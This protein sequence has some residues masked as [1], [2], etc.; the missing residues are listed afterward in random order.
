MTDQ[1]AAPKAA[2]ARRNPPKP[3]RELRNGAAQLEAGA[4]VARLWV[5]LCQGEPHFA[6]LIVPSELRE[7][8]GE[9]AKVHAS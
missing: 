9:L 6:E 3:S 2:P 7:A 1:N 8:L 4:R 5:E